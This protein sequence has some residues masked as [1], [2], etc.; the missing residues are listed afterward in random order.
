MLMRLSLSHH[1]W[2]PDI[3]VH[4][5]YLLPRNQ[6]PAQTRL[7]SNWAAA[8]QIF[9]QDVDTIHWIATGSDPS[10]ISNI[11]YDTTVS[12]NIWHYTACSPSKAIDDVISTAYMFDPIWWSN[13]SNPSQFESGIIFNYHTRQPCVQAHCSLTDLIGINSPIIGEEIMDYDKSFNVNLTEGEFLDSYNGTQDSHLIWLPVPTPLRNN[14]SILAVF[15]PS[16]SGYAPDTRP[17]KCG[18]QAAWLPADITKLLPQSGE[19]YLNSV[20]PP[21]IRKAAVDNQESIVEASMEPILPIGVEWM[22]ASTALPLNHT[23]YDSNSDPT[24]QDILH[25]LD[26]SILNSPRN[27]PF[28][29]EDY[30]YAPTTRKLTAMLATV[31]ASAMAT[32]DEDIQDIYSLAQINSSTA[33]PDFTKINV[34]I[35]TPGVGYAIHVAPE[36]LSAVVL[37][38]YCALALGYTG[39]SIWT[40]LSSNSWDSVAELVALALNSRRP[41]H[42]EHTSAGIETLDIFREPI[43]ILENNQESIELA[44]KNNNSS[45]ALYKRITRNKAY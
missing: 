35:H 37:C 19:V 36:I 33:G 27:D 31:V 2:G 34:D 21:E 18:L 30:V 28:A 11:S 1:S 41:E 15:A 3:W 8:E 24:I 13:V 44:F 26:T 7:R 5:K 29:D 4:R 14:Y 10:L 6:V 16:Y 25:R 12:D 42:M 38:L 45:E 32:P 9:S 39:W 20:V 43:Q 22:I 17:W 23:A 40:G